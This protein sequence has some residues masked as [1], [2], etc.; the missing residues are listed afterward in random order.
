MN[1]C[2]KSSLPFVGL[3]LCLAL[4]V[5]A[6]RGQEVLPPVA[7]FAASDEAAL[8]D[9][10]SQ[11]PMVP[12]LRYAEEGLKQLNENV[13]DY[14][15][16]LVKREQVNGK[17]GGYQHLEVKVRH[18]QAND[19]AAPTP[20]SIYLKFLAPSTLKDREVLYVSN[21]NDGDIV[22]R[23]GGRRLATLTMRLDPHGRLAMEDQRYPITEI[24]VKVLV[25][26]L[27]EVMH[28]DMQYGECEVQFYRDAKLNGRSCTHIQVVH[29]VKRPHFRYHMARVFIDNDLGVP[30]YFAS[31]DWPR[32]EGGPPQLL[33][34]YAYT[35]VQLNV[36]FT[37]LDFD[38]A[39]P[40][41]GFSP[42]S[43]DA[44]E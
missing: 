28:E 44:S 36:G 10:N 21:Q 33:E 14:S 34:E 15:C 16:V 30:V 11:H 32:E 22:A 37:D 38:R 3:S 13:R 31:Y 27:I 9:A 19:S 41:Y 4:P 12:V 29:P 25:E 8:A 23:R 35:D 20:K 42:E 17:L 26:R 1:L 2:W 24:G 43:D 39:N 40:N 18:E 5:A 6:V 7:P